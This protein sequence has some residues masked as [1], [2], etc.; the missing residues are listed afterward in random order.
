MFAEAFPGRPQG[1]EER[2]W[3]L[4]ALRALEAR[5]V[6]RLPAETGARWNT[7]F[8]PA[9]P[10]SVDLA[11]AGE[12]SSA[13]AWKAFPWHPTLS[14][15]ANLI[16]LPIEHE[17]FLLKVH[18][19]LVNGWFSRSAP[20]KYRSIQLTGDEKR[21][22][23]LAKSALFGEGR[24]TLDLIGCLQEIPPLAW[25]SVSDNQ[26]A[27]IF[28]NAGP[29]SV[30]RDVLGQ[31][32]TSP[33][34]IIAYG[35]G[36]GLLT[37]LPHLRSIGRPVGIIHYVGDLDLAGLEIALAARD[38]ARRH[39]LPEILPAPGA[40]L[41]MLASAR[42]L[43]ASNGWKTAS[44]N[45]HRPERLDTAL[46]FLPEDARLL[47]RP[48]ITARNRVPEEVLGPDELLDLFQSQRA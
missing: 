19:G 13:R 36:N 38:V 48:I 41:K 14:W 2:R 21:L 33:Y 23:L 25:A 46:K 47:A 45:R 44:M 37:S 29:F 12:P 42:A 9:V 31:M 10:T 22:G 18:E 27:I 11:V 30:A 8:A 24:L 32:A 43:G 39:G 17:R 34:G 1:A 28:E 35:G 15:I 7:T 20:L 26:A 5:R 3:F 4:E 40:H 16:H 6:V